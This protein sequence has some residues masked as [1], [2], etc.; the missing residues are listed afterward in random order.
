MNWFL[1]ALLNPILHAFINHF[2]K[3]LLSKYIK[4]GTVGALILFSA[5]FAVVALPVIFFINPQVL[6][7]VSFWQGLILMLNGALLTVAILFY[8]YALDT[9]EASYVAP[10]FQLVPVFGFITGFLILGE[11]LTSQQVVAGLVILAGSFLL[12]LELNEG[13]TRIKKKMVLLMLGSSFFYAINAVIFKSIAVHQGFLDSLFWDMAGKFLFGVILYF[14]VASYR[15]E[16][17]HLIK[18]SGKAVISLNVFNEIIGL[19]GE[20]ALIFA[21]L[22]APVALVQSVS[23]MQPA[24]VLIIGV[25]LTVFSPKFAEESLT[26]KF[27]A[28]KILGIVIITIGVYLLEFSI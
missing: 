16:F 4:G 10:F 11:V 24:F 9:D 17:I 7:S 5:L 12:S 28:Q 27:L 6:S 18:V 3:Y 26:R 2:D 1:I 19:I 25:F 15:K 13:K 23:G 22:Y 21:V 20:F 14:A 8:L